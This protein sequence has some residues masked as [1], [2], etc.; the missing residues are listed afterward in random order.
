M[1]IYRARVVVEEGAPIL[2]CA[3]G[4]MVEHPLV[5]EQIG[6]I[7]GTEDSVMGLSKDIV[8]RLLDEMKDQVTHCKESMCTVVSLYVNCLYVSYYIQHSAVLCIMSSAVQ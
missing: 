4:L 1:E 3:G 2:S 8:E 7:E 6:R 5:K